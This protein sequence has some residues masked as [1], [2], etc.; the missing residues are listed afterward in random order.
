[1]HPLKKIILQR[2]NGFEC[3]APFQME[4][5]KNYF[6]HKK[7]GTLTL[8]VSKTRISYWKCVI[9]NHFKDIWKMWQQNWK[10][11]QIMILQ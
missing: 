6:W 5:S 4:R 9:L 3:N 2:P 7:T 11:L 10:D 8:Q 1:M